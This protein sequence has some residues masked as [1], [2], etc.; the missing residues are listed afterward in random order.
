M[1]EILANVQKHIQEYREMRE[2]CETKIK[3]AEATKN[4]PQNKQVITI[5]GDYRQN[6]GIPHVGEEQPGDTYYFS[7]KNLYIFGLV[8]VSKKKLNA[9]LPL[10]RR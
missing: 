6:L 7:P 2:I 10:L 8:D 9:S 1:E 4:L 3:L 5:V